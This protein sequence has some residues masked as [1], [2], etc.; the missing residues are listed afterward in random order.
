MIIKSDCD[1]VLLSTSFMWDCH[2]FGVV[3]SYQSRVIHI[4]TENE[5][6]LPNVS[7][8]ILPTANEA[9]CISAI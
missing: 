1:L 4:E 5:N 8:D 2:I 7:V 3:F 9:H 6:Y